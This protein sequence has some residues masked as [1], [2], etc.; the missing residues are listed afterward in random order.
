MNYTI[1]CTGLPCHVS[2]HK[3]YIIWLVA[4]VCVRTVAQ[5]M[6]IWDTC[7]VLHPA[8]HATSKNKSYIIWLG[9]SHLHCV[10]TV[11]AKIRLIWHSNYKLYL[12]GYFLPLQS[13]CLNAQ[14]VAE[15]MLILLSLTSIPPNR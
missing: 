12:I 8:R 6:P 10:C 13:V 14:G 4:P 2:K 11:F 1:T 9:H 3:S 7:T 5:F 15:K